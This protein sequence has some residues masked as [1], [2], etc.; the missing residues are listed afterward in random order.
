MNDF[1]RERELARQ[2]NLRDKLHDASKPI[3]D[4]ERARN[5]PRYAIWLRSTQGARATL[6]GRL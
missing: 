1:D 4:D 6:K 2:R 3:T 5:D